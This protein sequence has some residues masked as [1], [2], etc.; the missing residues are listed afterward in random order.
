MSE[1]RVRELTYLFTDIEGSTRRWQEAPDEMEASVR[2]HDHLL[3]ETI[4]RHGGE[5]V[6]Q[7]GDGVFAAFEDPLAAIEAAREGQEA[8]NEGDRLDPN[9]SVRMA[10][11]SG[12][13]LR[14]GTDYFGEEV[15]RAARL[16]EVGHGGQILVSGVTAQLVGDSLSAEVSLDDLGN[17]R[18]RDLSE[19]ISV[20]QLV[21]NQLSDTFPPLRSIDG[22][23][24]NLPADTSTFIGRSADIALVAGQ[25]ETTRLLSLTGAGGSGKTRL[26]LQAAAE[27]LPKFTDGAWFVDLS[28]LRDPALVAV[29]IATTLHVAEKAGRAWIEVLADHLSQRRI[30]LLIDNCEH[31]IDSVAGAAA[32]L[33]QAAPNLRILATTREPLSIPGEV[34]W[35]VP[36][37]HLPDEHDDLTLDELVG[38]ESARLFV[39]RALAA[40]PDL[41][42]SDEDAPVI[43]DL[44]RR[45]DGLPL[46]LE[47]AAARV[48]ALSIEDI[49]KYLGDRF[50]L[51]SKGSRT[52][53]PRHRTLEGA[54]AW[55][56]ELL[57]DAEQDLFRRLSVF[58][59]GFDLDAALEVAPS[60][61]LIEVTSLVDKS[62]LSADTGRTKT[63]YRMLE[64]VAAFG[65][66]RL[67]SDV[68]TVRDTHL[69]WAA[70]L[71]Q[72]AGT[73]LQG[74]R[75]QEWLD[76]IATELDNLR[77]AMQWSLDGGNPLEGLT[78]ATS[79]FR[80]WYI[81][82]VREGKRWFELLL[83]AAPKETSEL[84]ARALFSAGS[85]MIS[86]GEE[87]AAASLLK[88]SLRIFEERDLR[89]GAAYA[90][91]YLMRARWG[92][93]PPAELRQMVDADLEAFRDVSDQAG[94]ALT[95]I[96]D[97]M[98]HLQF[99][100]VDDIE[101]VPELISS[102]N[103]VGAPQLVA[104]A[105]EI[106]GVVSWFRGD[107]D[108]AADLLNEAAGIYIELGNPQ[109]ASHCLENTAGWANRLGM[110][111]EAALLLG[112]ASSLRLDIGIPTPAYE[113][114]LFDEILASAKAQLTNEF[115]DH[116]QRGWGLSMEEALAH[117]RQ[118]TS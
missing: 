16:V 116:W 65:L 72:A 59:G 114:Y 113:S 112:A 22:Y 54:V 4:E 51:L 82:A 83:K 5:W 81:R 87:E 36:I 35:H 103:A 53:L 37:M 40:R 42:L 96:F 10:L 33:L 20:F 67:G 75:Q 84:Q 44:C 55:S 99:G 49:A 95:L 66:A 110:F 58:R 2:Q 15:N 17:H 118:L 21:T 45:L 31:L 25:L 61:S 115:D 76:R 71:S 8:L 6:K 69:E 30:L 102:A 78:I 68:G 74:P 34:T 23:P 97:S 88:E 106:P 117:V 79:L 1:Q 63:R 19:P 46:A 107:F 27:V 38:F 94:I 111:E 12:A 89:G 50:T 85:L 39:E 104:H 90:L 24:N 3:R 11:H 62:L 98:W 18:L 93:A 26:A 28:G 80:F 57:D 14:R 77:S 7:T 43:A 29:Q 86:Q 92:S 101:T 32:H 100:S 105:A 41:D 109:C 9:L 73:E 52:A 56:Y 13:A 108:T 47:L 60:A 48:R 70:D 64:T 91:H